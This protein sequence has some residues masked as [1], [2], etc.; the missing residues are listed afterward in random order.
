MST[1]SSG[2]RGRWP[3]S[4]PALPADCLCA[5]VRPIEALAPL[6]GDSAPETAFKAFHLDPEAR[7]RAAERVFPTYG[8]HLSGGFLSHVAGKLFYRTGIDGLRAKIHNIEVDGRQN[9]GEAALRET[10]LCHL[11][12]ESWEDWQRSYRY[13]MQRG[14]Y[15]AELKPQVN[16]DAG[17]LS[18]HALFSQIEAEAGEAGLRGFYQEVCLATPAL[19]ERLA[20]EGLL[21]RHDLR[22]DALRQAHFP[23][24]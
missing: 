10:E 12:A 15:R 4:W 8:R 18:L 7:Q 19:C 9:P 16:R 3:I 24:P 23:A 6:P 11:H 2:R 13:R 5:R 20:A 17:G 1:N 14:S 21:R 22:L